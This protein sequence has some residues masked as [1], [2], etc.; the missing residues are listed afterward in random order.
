MGH[1]FEA[2]DKHFKKNILLNEED[3]AS[4][5]FYLETETAIFLVMLRKSR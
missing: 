2:G 5:D 3:Q 1:S 4:V